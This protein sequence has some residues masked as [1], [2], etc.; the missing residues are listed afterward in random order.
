MNLNIISLFTTKHK[1][2]HWKS[3]VGSDVTFPIEI[4]SPLINGT[5]SYITS[6]GVFADYLLQMGGLNSTTSG[7]WTLIFSGTFLDGSWD[8]ISAGNNC[9]KHV[10]AGGGVSFNYTLQDSHRTWKMMVWKMIF[11]LQG[12]VPQVPAINHFIFRGGVLYFFAG[13]GAPVHHVWWF[14]GI[15]PDKLMTHA[16]LQMPPRGWSRL[17]MGASPPWN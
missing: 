15:F 12:R 4:N 2:V 11:L 14:W 7:M 3:M 6:G 8:F 1:H 17:C 13:N 16:R 9:G 10:F 5:N